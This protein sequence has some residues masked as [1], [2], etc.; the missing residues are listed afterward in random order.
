MNVIVFLLQSL[1]EH[2][3]ESNTVNCDDATRTV[4]SNNKSLS[5]AHKWRRK[6]ATKSHTNV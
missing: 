1:G 5:I 2:D 6:K 3:I 4:T